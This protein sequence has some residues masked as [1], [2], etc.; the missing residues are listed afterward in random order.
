MLRSISLV[1][2]VLMG[3]QPAWAGD[4]VDAAAAYHHVNPVVLRAIAYVE[5]RGQN[6]VGVNRNGTVDMGP[7]QINSIHLATLAKHGVSKD[8]LMEPCR[9]VFVGAWHLRR[10][11]NK[12]GNTWEAVGAYHN[13]SPDKRDAYSRKIQAVVMAWTKA[14]ATRQ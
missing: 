11:M 4:C 10:M 12:Y 13:A 3:G 2:A 8:D 9:N 6:L 14:G 7:M 1:A 5:S